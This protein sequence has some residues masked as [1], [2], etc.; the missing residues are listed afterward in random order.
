MRNLNQEAKDQIAALA[1]AAYRAA[2]SDGT[3]P[4]AQVPAPPAE[5]PKDTA[6]GDFT[7]TFAMA[8]ARALKRPPRAIAQAVL[9][10]LDLS[11]SFFTSAEIAGPGFLNFRLGAKW[12]GEVLSASEQ[13]G[14]GSCDMLAGQKIMV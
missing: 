11:D 4:E 13:E 3:L 2:V 6:N 14:Y 10:H 7:T 12:Y 9:D 1:L 8:A 5:V